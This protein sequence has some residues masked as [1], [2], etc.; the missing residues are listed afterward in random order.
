[1]FDGVIGTE[2]FYA[3][4]GHG[5]RQSRV[6]HDVYLSGV[7]SSMGCLRRPAYAL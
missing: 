4:G 7:A 5:D 1:M 3:G 6:R 2:I